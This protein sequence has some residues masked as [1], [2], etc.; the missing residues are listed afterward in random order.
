LLLTSLLGQDQEMEQFLAGIPDFY[1]S[2]KV[3][4]PANVLRELNKDLL[5]RVIVSFMDRSLSSHLFSDITVQKRIRISLRAMEV[6]PYLLQR[7]FHRAL[8]SGNTTI[9]KCIDFLRLADRYTD[10]VDLKLCCLAKCIVA[11]A[12][13]RLENRGSDERWAEIVQRGLNWSQSQFAK[14]CGQRDSVKLRNLVKI[15]RELS[16]AHLGYE[17]PSARDIIQDTLHV[18]R[19]LNIENV[20]NELRAEFCELW[21]QLVGSM[22]IQDILRDRVMRSNARLLL[23]L[24]RDIYI[25]LHEG[26]DTRRFALPASAYGLD[27][28]AA[29]YALCN[30]STHRHSAPTPEN[31]V[32]VADNDQEA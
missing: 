25:S 22:Q 14:Y 23:S 5:P 11:V 19:Q 10:D 2:K 31:T 15:A 12:I 8:C 30:V 1:A 4:D 9:F 26:T 13:N 3:E 32:T 18:V 21:D 17:D 27:S 7:T 24:T 6:D 16:S 20:S 29:T 28:N